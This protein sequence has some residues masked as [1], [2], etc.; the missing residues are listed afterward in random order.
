MGKANNIQRHHPFTVRLNIF[1][2]FRRNIK[3]LLS[4]IKILIT[5]VIKMQA[6]KF[7]RVNLKEEKSY[8]TQR[9]AKL[10]SQ[11]NFKIYKLI[12]QMN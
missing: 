6:S 1:N 12:N 11:N 4:K 5:D 7:V 8:Q 10:K 2:V 9:L 3:F